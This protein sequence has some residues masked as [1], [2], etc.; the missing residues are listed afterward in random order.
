MFCL[1]VCLLITSVSAET[2]DWKICSNQSELN[3]I[4]SHSRIEV[5]LFDLVQSVVRCSM[6]ANIYS[7]LSLRGI[8]NR[9]LV[10]MFIFTVSRLCL[11]FCATAIVR[12]HLYVY[13]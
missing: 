2:S 3:Q 9:F 1:L 6:S 11:H 8:F 4:D 13:N 10:T 5:I 7:K 12:C